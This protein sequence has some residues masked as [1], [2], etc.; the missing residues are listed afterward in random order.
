MSRL[1]PFGD[2]THSGTY[3]GNL[4]GVMAARACLVEITREG[5]Y[6]HIYAIADQLYNG[7][8]QIFDRMGIPARVQGL[9]A[10]FGIYFG[11]T[12]EVKTFS[13]TLKHDT[14]LAG[15][16]MSACTRH[17]VY[18]HNYGKIALGHHG[19]SASHTKTDINEALN[20]IET[21]VKDLIK[22]NN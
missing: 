13:D 15:N 11:I 9:G 18:F 6:D 2:V 10:R 8:S 4:L 12:D 22:A 14:K 21:A 7:L 3:T 20:R 5:F 1:T 19:F 16:F 17:G